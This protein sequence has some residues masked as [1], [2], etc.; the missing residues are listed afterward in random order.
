MFLG[1]VIAW[2]GNLLDLQCGEYGYLSAL[3]I[4]SGNILINTTT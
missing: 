3:A 2:I 4:K 1:Y